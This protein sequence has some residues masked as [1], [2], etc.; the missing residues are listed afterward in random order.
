VDRLVSEE[1]DGLWQE[2]AELKRSP[3]DGVDL[4]NEVWAY[5]LRA[6]RVRLG[7]PLSDPTTAR[8]IGAPSPAA[9]LDEIGDSRLRTIGV[10]D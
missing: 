6:A 2:A 8:T 10:G 5:S 9:V 7:L 3:N 1:R 4:A